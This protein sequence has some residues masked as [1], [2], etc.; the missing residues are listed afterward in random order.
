MNIITK[1]SW[2]ST[3]AND[4]VFIKLRG[5]MSLQN[6]NGQTITR[7]L[8]PDMYY[9]FDNSPNLSYRDR[10]TK[11]LFHSW[12]QT[13]AV[14]WTLYSLFRVIPRPLNFKCPKNLIP[15]ILSTYTV[16]EDGTECSE[17]STYTIQTPGIH[18]NKEFKFM[19]YTPIHNSHLLFKITWF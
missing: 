10:Q 19:F 18:P 6:C 16:Y 7:L 13:F 5:E 14:F 12:L 8:E 17:T 1:F 4:S 15:V 2:P 11:F 3:F 9:H